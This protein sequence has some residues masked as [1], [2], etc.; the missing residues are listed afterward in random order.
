MYILF[1]VIYEIIFWIIAGLVWFVEI[2]IE[3]EKLQAS[4][5]LGFYADPDSVKNYKIP[6][7]ESILWFEISFGIQCK[8][9]WTPQW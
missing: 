2:S 1:N 8:K 5:E 6:K 3:I 9:S 4:W 7:E